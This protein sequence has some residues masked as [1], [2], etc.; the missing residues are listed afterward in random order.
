MTNKIKDKPFSIDTVFTVS[1]YG[2][3][4][5][6]DI[7]GEN[8]VYASLGTTHHG[9]QCNHGG[10]HPNHELMLVKLK[11]VVDLLLE[12]EELNKIK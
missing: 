11:E 3:N 2:K 6:F 1:R 7:D 12:I 9:L 4:P 5:T 8:L 10:A